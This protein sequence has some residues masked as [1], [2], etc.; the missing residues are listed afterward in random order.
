MTL[1]ELFTGLG[2]VVGALLFWFA[3][4]EKHLSTDGVWKLAA[5]GLLCGIAGAK[6]T[7]FLATPGASLATALD[8]RSG[9]RAQL[10]GMIF[11]W[12]GVEI[13]KRVMGIKRSTGDLFAFLMTLE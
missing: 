3:A 6:L 13:A 8:P 5:I 10:G 2:F 7:Q 12:I 4:R 1:G 11:G 9:G